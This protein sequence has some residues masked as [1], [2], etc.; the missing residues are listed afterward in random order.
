MLNQESRIFIFFNKLKIFLV[1]GMNLG[2][3]LFSL[4]EKGKQ[5]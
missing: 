5:S 4:H 1:F 2:F 3:I